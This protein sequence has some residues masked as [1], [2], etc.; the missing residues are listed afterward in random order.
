[1]QR[2]M[3]GKKRESAEG[4]AELPCDDVSIATW[5]NYLLVASVHA[6]FHTIFEGHFGFLYYL[7]WQCI[8]SA[9]HLSSCFQ[10]LKSLS[11]AIFRHP[12]T[13]Q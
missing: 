13:T 2:V 5:L 9:Y 8:E 1:M 12:Q 7:V 4:V 10:E 11:L 3:L 6:S